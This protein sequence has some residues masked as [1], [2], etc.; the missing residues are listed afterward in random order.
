MPRLSRKYFRHLQERRRQ[1][2]I[3]MWSWILFTNAL[4]G[5]W[6]FALGR[7]MD[8]S[9][10]SIGQSVHI[11]LVFMGVFAAARQWSCRRDVVRELIRAIDEANK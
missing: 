6:L 8:P 5:I 3:W 9:Q 4:I 7:G 1:A 2:G 11:G 10:E